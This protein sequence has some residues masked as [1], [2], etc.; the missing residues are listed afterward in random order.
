MGLGLI[1]PT[2]RKPGQQLAVGVKKNNRVVNR[3]RSVVERVSAQIK[4]WRV[5]HTGFRRLLGVCG[6]VFSVVW[7]L[8]FLTA[9]G[10]FE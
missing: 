6:R 3:L 2:K 10:N 5:L 4:T 9:G 1:T 8:G 7:R